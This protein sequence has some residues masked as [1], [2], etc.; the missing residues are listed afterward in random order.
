MKKTFP[1]V[2]AVFAIALI[3]IFSR[4]SGYLA[5]LWPANSLILGLM[6]R[7][8]QLARSGFW[9]WSGLAMVVADL[10][11]GST[12]IKALVLNTGNIFSVMAGLIVARRWRLALYPVKDVVDV[13]SIAPVALAAA[14]AAGLFGMYANPLLFDGSVADGFTYWLVTEFVNYVVFLPL[15]IVAPA[16]SALSSGAIKACLARMNLLSLLPGVSVIALCLLAMT[17]S[18]PGV[19]AVPLIG[20]LWCAFAYSVFSTALITLVYCV[21]TLISLSNGYIDPDQ[22]ISYWL[23][24]ISLRVTV[25]MVALVPIILSCYIH[26]NRSRLRDLEYASNHDEL[27]GTLTRRALYNLV[28]GEDEQ[29]ESMTLLMID[30]DHFKSINDNHGHP[31]GDRVLK[32]FVEIARRCLRPD[33]AFCRMGGEEFMVVLRDL[34]ADGANRVAARIR[35]SFEESPLIL[36]SGELIDATVSIGVAV[37]YSDEDDFDALA[38]KADRALYEAKQSG[39]NRIIHFAD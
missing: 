30:L 23:N 27:T 24:V 26:C 37:R 12:V 35:A 10:I 7:N 15:F 19:I 29:P 16:F 32:H 33:D 22:Q 38:I 36:E 1:L 17:I 6:L 20:L 4:P 9:L 21:W 8:P 2:L 13:L 5:D 3:G 11:T 14:V 28:Q 31:V 34:P 39:R 25:A 18:G